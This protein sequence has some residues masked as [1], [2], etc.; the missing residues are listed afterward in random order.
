MTVSLALTILFSAGCL[1]WMLI[2][3]IK[4]VEACLRWFHLSRSRREER[5]SLA[6]LNPRILKR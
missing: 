1:T 2:E 6:R 5:K 4:F 3:W